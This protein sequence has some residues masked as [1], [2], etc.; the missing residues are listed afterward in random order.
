M[1]AP[2]SLLVHVPAL[3]AWVGKML[4]ALT[5]SGLPPTGPV[6]YYRDPDGKPFY[7][8]EPKRKKDGRAYVA[9]RASEDISF[10]DRPPNAAPAAEAAAPGGGKRVLYYR[11]PM[12]LPDTSPVQARAFPS[13]RACAVHNPVAI[14]SS[15]ATGKCDTGPCSSA[16][17]LRG[18]RRSG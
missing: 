1:P 4:P 6:I 9:V 17:P 10:E 14:V 3:P 13:T 12:G 15:M 8:L 7:A 18:A 2:D 11:N 5:Q 16:T